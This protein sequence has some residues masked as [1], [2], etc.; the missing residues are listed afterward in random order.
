MKGVAAGFGNLD[1]WMVDGGWRSLSSQT[2]LTTAG[3]APDVSGPVPTLP[4]HRLRALVWNVSKEFK[5][6][7][8]KA[9]NVREDTLAAF[10]STIIQAGLQG[11]MLSKSPQGSE[12]FIFR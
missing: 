9:F 3:F 11:R 12:V 4:E 7:P 5:T 8:K 10:N 6:L 1:L 2:F